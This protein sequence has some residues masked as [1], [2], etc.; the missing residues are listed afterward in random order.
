MANKYIILQNDSIEHEG[1][2]LYRIKALRS[3]K[4]VSAGDLGGYVEGE[5]NLSQTGTCWIFDDAKVFDKAIVRDEA[6]I[7]NEAQVFGEAIVE[8][9]SIVVEQAKIYGYANLRDDSMV[10]GHGEVYEH[11]RLSNKAVV[12]NHAKV[13]GNARVEG[14]ASVRNFAEVYGHARVTGYTFV[15][16]DAKVYDH[17][18]IDGH[19]RIY[20]HASVKD[21]G[22][23]RG[24]ANLSGYA[25]VSKYGLVSDMADVNFNIRGQ[26]EYAI[27]T[28]PIESKWFVTAATKENWFNAKGMTGTKEEF[29]ALARKESPEKEETYRKIVDLH[30]DLYGLK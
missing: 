30:L 14:E 27:Y 26:D 25:T 16:G 9:R 8:E 7:T 12:E 6:E 29:L 1:R 17:A 11:T 28:D 18:V 4:W 24:Y 15:D 23:V 10:M 22:I 20:E 3:F 13:Y 21:N 2:I 5:H 19:A